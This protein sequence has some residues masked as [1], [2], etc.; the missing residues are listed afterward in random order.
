M[1]A[2]S[3]VTA[4]AQTP[5]QIQTS[6]IS[7]VPFAASLQ[8]TGLV[9]G[10]TRQEVVPPMKAGY[11]EGVTLWAN[12]IYARSWGEMEQ[13]FGMKSY[14]YAN[15]S[16]SST[17]LHHDMYQWANGSGAYYDGKFHMVS[18]SYTYLYCEYRVEGWELLHNEIDATKFLGLV[19]TD[20]DYDPTTGLTYGCF[21]N[22]T[23]KTYE[24]ASVD[25]ETLT[26]TSI[27]PMEEFS[28]IAIDAEGWIYGVKTSDGGLYTID[29]KTG[30]QTLVGLTGVMPHALQSMAFDRKTGILYWAVR[31]PG[32]VAYLATVNV[33]TG[34]VRRLAYLPDNVQLSCLYVPYV[35]DAGAPAPASDVTLSGAGNT[36]TV[37]FTMPSKT[38]DGESLT[39][40]DLTYSV[41]VNGEEKAGAT[42]APGAR[43]SLNIPVGDGYNAVIVTASNASGKSAPVDRRRWFGAD[44]PSA[45]PA[46]RASVADDADHTVSLGWD[47]PTSGIH[48]GLLDPTA[49]SYDVVRMP[50]EKAVATDLHATTF[51][52]VLG[53]DRVGKVYY[54]V[55]ARCGE[56][57]GE[58]VESEILLAGGAYGLPYFEGF[59]DKAAFNTYH[60]VDANGDGRTWGWNSNLSQAVYLRDFA[61]PRKA[62]DW[63]LTPEMRYN[64]G[65]AYCL[66]FEVRSNDGRN[67]ETLSV[68]VGRNTDVAGYTEILAPETI[69]NEEMQKRVVYF[70]VPADGFYRVGFHAISPAT[71]NALAIDNVSITD[72]ASVSAPGL[73]TDLVMNPDTQ[74]Y[75]VAVLSF[76][77]P[78][79]TLGG[80]PLTTV[81]KIEISRNDELIAT[82]TNVTAG[83]KQTFTD[84]AAVNGTNRYSVVAYNGADAGAPV[85][86]EDF[87]GQDFPVEPENVVAT[88]NGDHYTIS[89]TAPAAEGTHKLP[90][91]VDEL[92]YTISYG[93]RYT[94]LASDVKG[95]SYTITGDMV[96]GPQNLVS[97][98]VAA[99]TPAGSGRKGDSNT[100][101][102]G[103]PYSLP[104]R[105]SFA[106]GAVPDSYWWVG[107]GNVFSLTDLKSFD[108]DFGSVFM[109]TNN[110][111]RDNWFNTGKLRLGEAAKPVVSFAYYATPGVNYKLEICVT[112][113]GGDDIV[114]GTIDFSKLTGEPGWRTAVFD[115]SAGKKAEYA[116]VKFHSTNAVGGTEVF[117]DR[118]TVRDSQG[119]N[120]H[121]DEIS[122]LSTIYPGQTISVRANVENFGSVAAGGKVVF[123]A[124][125]NEFA[126]VDCP[127][128]DPDGSTVVTAEYVC[129]DGHKEPVALTAS[130]ICE[131]DT[132]LSDNGFDAL[133]V[134][135][136][137]LRLPVVSDLYAE[138]DA[139]GKGVALSWH[140]PNSKEGFVAESFETYLHKD[141]TFGEWMTYDGDHGHTYVNQIVDIGHGAEE[142]SF[143]IFSIDGASVPLNERDIYMPRSGSNMLLAMASEDLTIKKGDGNDDWLISPELTTDEAHSLSFWANSVKGNTYGFEKFEI[144]TSRGF[145]ND[146][147]SFELLGAYEVPQG[148]TNYTAELPE[149]TRFFAIR[150][151]SSNLYLFALDDIEFDRG[152]FSPKGFNVYSDGVRIASLDASTL[153]FLV[154]GT[155]AFNHTYNVTVVYDNGESPMSNNAFIGMAAGLTDIAAIL[156]DGPAD[157]YNLQGICVR[158]AATS[159]DDLPSGVYV[160]RGRKFLI[161]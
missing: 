33:N 39:S 29:K 57:R 76:T 119:C 73:V 62:D 142:A 102:V 146:I 21:W 148:W 109:R 136:V 16:I 161:P 87:V 159:L 10:E 55:A 31:A 38:A 149:G 24:F 47:A 56:N 43:L 49:V 70:T 137:D 46:L 126:R 140:D 14:T 99:V 17:Q 103:K 59:D 64:A 96:D 13:Y 116:F 35:A 6:E 85:V 26:H 90:V 2:F 117:L 23:L 74:G 91:L 123:Y 27:A 58:A 156:S 104:F 12:P 138:P 92:V 114:V 127:S 50:E 155:D 5:G 134:T 108:D 105:E 101:F 112:P 44:V 7:D 124:D 8:A 150:Y 60:V 53:P 133:T 129:P 86:V 113:A 36:M 83:S 144:Y 40:D 37:D 30:E 84:R 69:P 19:A 151:C 48:G 20:C 111:D 68:S 34:G 118:I 61:N 18:R 72:G 79:S 97:F 93:Y 98:H 15:G 4:A 158:R 77:V 63:L 110:T 130:I 145:P 28:G 120:L 67:P 54:I 32:S 1:M 11:A 125:G 78:S 80:A 153:N 66:S 88:D 139:D 9:R 106:R 51:T 75:P 160:T 115:L 122:A 71:A 121:A 135:P 25:Y 95:T 42:A 82:M 132:Q 131:G 107:G 154:E 41:V 152:D 100:L 81:S 52:D 147:E 45:I 141:D 3:A 65:R 89:W 128:V 22:P 143:W 94:T 157:I